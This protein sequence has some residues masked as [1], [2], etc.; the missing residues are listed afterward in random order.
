MSNNLVDKIN[1]ALLHAGMVAE[2][3]VKGEPIKSENQTWASRFAMQ[4]KGWEK[5]GKKISIGDN[6]FTVTQIYE[7]FKAIQDQAQVANIP[8][9]TTIS[10]IDIEEGLRALNKPRWKELSTDERYDLLWDLG[11]AVKPLNLKTIEG[12]DMDISTYRTTKCRHKRMDGTIV[13]G[14]AI[15]AQ[16]RRDREWIESGYA[17]DEA[18]LFTEDVELARDLAEMG[19]R[20]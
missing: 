15:I 10:L 9:A 6:S 16:E 14:I 11:L 18:K 1:I 3:L 13:Y 8:L 2:D 5:A 17:S 19:R 20:T 7:Y 4:K 12:Y